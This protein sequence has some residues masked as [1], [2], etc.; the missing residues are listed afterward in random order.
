MPRRP[1]FI[2]PGAAHHVTQRGNNRQP[3]FFTADDRLLYL[4]LLR[5]H[6]S[7]NGAHILGYCL[8]TNHVHLIVTPDREHSLARTFGGT[9]AEYALTLNQV[10]NRTGH[11]WQNRYFSCPLDDTHLERALLYVDLNPVRAGFAANACDWPW[12]SAR[13][14]STEGLTDPVLD[15]DWVDKA[16]GWDRADWLGR[17]SSSRT[18]EEDAPLRLA[19]LR[20]EP[21]GSTQFVAEL[22]L[23][24]GRRLRVLARGRP[25][26]PQ[27]LATAKFLQESMVA[28]G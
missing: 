12:S 13:V 4:R 25:R 2:V 9:H 8:M 6:A 1:R 23:R 28:S 16:G 24:A 5:Y 11:L 7:R 21:L 22:E 14:H 3:V 17:L 27:A 26:K 15:A 19:T 10:A 20:G 18:E